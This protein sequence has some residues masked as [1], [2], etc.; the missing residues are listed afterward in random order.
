MAVLIGWMSKQKATCG[1]LTCFMV[2][3]FPWQTIVQESSIEKRSQIRD[4]K[5]RGNLVA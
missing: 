2:I 5:L 3:V 4:K 1:L